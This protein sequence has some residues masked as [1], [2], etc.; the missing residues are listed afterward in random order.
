MDLTEKRSKR[1]FTEGKRFAFCVDYSSAHLSVRVFIVLICSGVVILFNESKVL[2]PL[3]LEHLLS[4]LL[5]GRQV[6]LTED[7]GKKKKS[8]KNMHYSIRVR[9]RETLQ[10]A[11]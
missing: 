6:S 9:E 3:S 8:M 11:G 1:L 10:T 7:G 4:A 2:L 5:V